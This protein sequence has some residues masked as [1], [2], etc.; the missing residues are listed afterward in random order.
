MGRRFT[1]E[2][3]HTLECVHCQADLRTT[4]ERT[5]VVIGHY[6]GGQLAACRGE[7]ARR[8]C[9]HP[10]GLPGEGEVLPLGERI[11]DWQDWQQM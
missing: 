2:M 7:C 11:A 10:G 8:A 9:G 5:Q 4:P 3:V 6:N 1:D